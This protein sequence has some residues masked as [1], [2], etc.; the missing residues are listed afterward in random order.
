MKRTKYKFAAG[1]FACSAMS[2]LVMPLSGVYA[3]GTSSYFDLNAEACI[4]E[5]Y[6]LEN[7][8]SIT[9][10][11]DEEFDAS[12]LT[13]LNC[14]DKEI[15]NLSG[16]T[17]FSNLVELN[18]SGNADL[19]LKDMDFSQNK[20]LK[21]IDVSGVNSD[22][23]NLSE[24]TEVTSII[25]DHDITVKT[26]TYIER[27]SD[28]EE[29]TYGMDLS[30][31]KFLDGIDFDLEE[32][33]YPYEYDEETKTIT[34]KHNI[35]D[36]VPVRQ[37]EYDLFIE[38]R[39]GLM[40]Y[41]LETKDDAEIEVLS[42]QALDDKCTEYEGDYVCISTVYYGDTF[43]STA[44]IED[45]FKKAF[46]LGGYE[47]TEVS[48]IPPTANVQLTTDEKN[49]KKGIV[50]ADAEFAIDFVYELKEIEVPAT[51]AFTIEGGTVV[52]AT[53]TVGIAALI[54]AFYAS[55]KVI[56]RAKANAKFKK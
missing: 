36:S 55:N 40:V 24:N 21:V 4:I 7:S 5:N 19:D 50:L 41:Y 54:I 27:L 22:Y 25:I 56:K 45:L 34:F 38:S 9:S 49:V 33:E 6:N 29:Y 44:V 17:L 11:E 18:V 53:A 23:I 35:P 10:L 12:K 51:G 3:E 8:T 37:G 30:E 13:V 42:S 46:N 52:A 48:I 15:T 32:K 14:P 2:G 39:S 26:P 1:V 20:E 31:L 47:L 43:D 28:E 16:I